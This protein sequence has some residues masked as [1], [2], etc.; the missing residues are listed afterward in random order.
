MSETISSKVLIEAEAAKLAS[1]EL[2]VATE[3]QRNS[4]LMA[5]ADA[6]ESSADEIETANA[7]DLDYAKQQVEQGLIKDALFQRLKFDKKKIALAADGI[8]QVAKLPDP[9]GVCTL[10]RELDQGLNLHRVSCPLG[11]VAVIFES[12]P[13][14]FPQIV[15]LSIKAGN[16]ILLKGG[17]EAERS[18]R[19]IYKALQTAIQKSGLPEHS[20]VLL[21]TR[22]DVNSMLKAEE[23]VDLVIPRGSNDL[24]R[25]VQNNTKIPVLGHADGVCHI[26]IDED[27]DEDKASRIVLDAKTQYPSACN[28]VETLLIHKSKLD[29]FLPNT[30]AALQGAGVEVRLDEV[31][32]ERLR[33]TADPARTINASLLKTATAEDWTSEYCEL[34][35]SIKSVDSLADAIQH[36]NKFG[37]SHTEAIIT[38]DKSKFE[39]FFQKVNSAGVFWN[40]S[41]RFAD[42][43]RYG[44]G[45]EVGISTARMHP[46]G[47]VGLEG[48]VTY[49]YKI[50]GSG[51]IVADYSGPDARPFTHRNLEI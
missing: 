26:Y 33:N 36:I 34:I 42:G 21:E 27:A 12:R 7:Q 37:S 15:S 46:R 23:F 49:K 50:E 43:F 8:R 32:S 4:A 28:S 10:A 35:V 9:L 30:V 13:D 14:A 19:A 38:E 2:A 1:A 45:A 47:P 25:F 24:V 18:N 17:K 3:A 39:T 29:S 48:L 51:H 31:C 6:L 20:V 11:V 41:T 22:E 16:A 5:M 44:F 40:A